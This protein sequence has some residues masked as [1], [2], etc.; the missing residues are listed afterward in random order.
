MEAWVLQVGQPWDG[1]PCRR[2]H[3]GITDSHMPFSG[4]IPGARCN[5]TPR[6][7]I[8]P[9]GR[10]GAYSAEDMT[11]RSSGRVTNAASA[12]RKSAMRVRRAEEIVIEVG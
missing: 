9:V 10:R 5:S 8:G 11:L 1:S 6:K 7:S 3:R 4:R 12:F 2:V